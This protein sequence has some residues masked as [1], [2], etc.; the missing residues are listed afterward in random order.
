M[1]LFAFLFLIFCLISVGLYFGVYFIYMSILSFIY[2]HCM[3]ARYLRKPEERESDPLELQMAVGH[4]V[5][6]GDQTQAFYKK[7]ECSKP[8]CHLP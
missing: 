4:H 1:G 8:L 7:K 3:C 2:G 6:A 5:G